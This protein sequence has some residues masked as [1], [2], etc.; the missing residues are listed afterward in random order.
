MTIYDNTSLLPERCISPTAGAVPPVGS[1]TA[2]VVL[3]TYSP[4]NDLFKLIYSSKPEVVICADGGAN[5][6]YDTL[7]S[8]SP[9][10]FLPHYI[11]G[12]LDSIRADVRR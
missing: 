1:P 7:S 9:D 10:S 12:D 11:V 6:L 5:R 2:L 8:P 3:N 4:S